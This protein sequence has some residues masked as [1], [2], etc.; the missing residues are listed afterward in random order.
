MNKVV[1]NN[2]NNNNTSNN[3]SN[4]NKKKKKRMPHKTKEMNGVSKPNIFFFF[5]FQMRESTPSL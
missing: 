3:N 5:A 2:N 4:N 1:E